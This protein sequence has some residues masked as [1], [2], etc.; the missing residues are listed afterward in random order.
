MTDVMYSP[1]FIPFY[2]KEAKE[3]GFSKNEAIIYGFIRFYT[4][5][6]QRFYFSNAQ[7]AEITDCGRDA[8]TQAVAKFDSM[9]LFDVIYSPKADGGT[10]RFINPGKP[11]TENQESG[12]RLLK[13]SSP[14]TEKPV[15]GLEETVQANNNTNNNN[16]Y[17][18][19][20][21]NEEPNWEELDD[22]ELEEYLD[23]VYHSS[24]K[25]EKKR[26]KQSTFGR[27]FSKRS[28]FP[29]KTTPISAHPTI[30]SIT[31]EE[32]EALAT[33][34]RLNVSEVTK[35]LEDLRI[36]CQSKGVSYGD[37]LAGLESF[38]SRDIQSGKL[39]PNKTMT[40][41]LLEAGFE[42]EINGVKVNNLE[43]YKTEYL[44]MEA[45]SGK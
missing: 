23:G 9:G 43:D 27:T 18:S 28:S 37:Y 32:I 4:K 26:R 38:I 30:V 6:G 41:M 21:V 34:Y 7:I 24:A 17:K 1:E 20:I 22:E 8:V 29:K 25:E 33:K 19:P 2:P 35:K 3:Y 40:E 13:T 14:T 16:I 42:V 36:Y 5:N 10:I 11:T 39:L 15:V 45:K 31:Q 44:K 12:S